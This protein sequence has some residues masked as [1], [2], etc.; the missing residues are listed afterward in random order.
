MIYVCSV[1]GDQYNNE[2]EIEYCNE[3]DNIFCGRC[4]S[5]ENEDICKDCGSWLKE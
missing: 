1:C 3:C 2:N 4:V 5:G